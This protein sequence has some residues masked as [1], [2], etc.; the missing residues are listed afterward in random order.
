V[1]F[2][3][4]LAPSFFGTAAAGA[5]L[6]APLAAVGSAT[7]LGP[8]AVAAVTATPAAAA[9]FLGTGMSFWQLAGL[10][11]SGVSAIG[12]IAGNNE[13]AAAQQFSISRQLEAGALE[14]ARTR[15][16]VDRQ[17]QLLVAR[18]MVGLAAQGGTGVG[19][20]FDLLTEPVM[21][22]SLEGIQ[23][24]TELDLQAGVLRRRS[25]NVTTGTV[26][27]NLGALGSG[28]ARMFSLLDR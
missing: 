2:L 20:T 6:A 13:N 24:L 26:R 8:A 17:S 5:S 9:G 14:A 4:A 25:S 3:A 15:R 7:T 11:M 18:R 10:G 16:E 23:R 21:E 27:A 12:T 22:T 28:G 1:A 19:S